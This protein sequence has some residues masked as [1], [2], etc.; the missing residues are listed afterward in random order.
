MHQNQNFMMIIQNYNIWESVLALCI[1]NEAYNKFLEII[2]IVYEAIEK[3]DEGNKNNWVTNNSK[4]LKV[5]STLG[6]YLESCIYRAT[7]ILWGDEIE[8]EIFSDK[9]IKK[10]VGNE[11]PKEMRIKFCE[12]KMLLKTA[13]PTI[14]D[15]YDMKRVYE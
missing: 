5:K 8:T 7:S 6:L 10:I 11:K 2:K 15:L 4:C 3:V 14:I 9:Y 1:I 13:L 12:T